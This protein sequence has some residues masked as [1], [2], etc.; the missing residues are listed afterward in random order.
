ML[1]ANAR[2]GSQ[3]AVLFAIIEHDVISTM[4]VAVM[5]RSE[6]NEN[7]NKHRKTII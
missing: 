6:N 5:T 4:V 2:R 7:S 1:W 3:Q